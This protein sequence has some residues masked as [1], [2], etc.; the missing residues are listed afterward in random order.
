MRNLLCPTL[1]LFRSRQPD[2]GTSI[3][4]GTELHSAGKGNHVL[5][6]SRLGLWTNTILHG[7]VV[8][9]LDRSPFQKIIEVG[10]R[11]CAMLGLIVLWLAPLL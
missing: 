10:T 2:G 6:L 4:I 7:I 9:S 3:G 8:I 5:P 11:L 1:L